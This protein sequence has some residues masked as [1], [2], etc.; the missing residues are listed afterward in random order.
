MTVEV[1]FVTRV[2]AAGVEGGKLR[3]TLAFLPTA[4]GRGHGKDISIA[5]W[6]SGIER[7]LPSGGD[8]GAS[9]LLSIR[10]IAVAGPGQGG[11]PF[12]DRKGGTRL[13]FTRRGTPPG[14]NVVRDL[15]QFVMTGRDGDAATDPSWGHLRDAL[16]HTQAGAATAGSIDVLPVGRSDAALLYTLERANRILEAIRCKGAPATEARAGAP[17]S[18]VPSLETWKDAYSLNVPDTDGSQA[19]KAK[20]DAAAALQAEATR[21]E[22]VI[23]ETTAVIL[24]NGTAQANLRSR[25]L[26]RDDTDTPEK[27]KE[28]LGAARDCRPC[29]SAPLAVATGARQDEVVRALHEAALLPDKRTKGKDVEEEPPPEDAILAERRLFGLEAH[30]TL[31]RLFNLVVD[32]EIGLDQLA[33]LEKAFAYKESGVVDEV[34]E[35]AGDGTA[36]FLFLA[37][38]FDGED[39]SVWTLAKL[40]RRGDAVRHFWPCTREEME[41]RWA[42]TATLTEVFDL[43]AANQVDGVVDLGME[44]TVGAAAHCGAGHHPRY[45][46]VT[47]NPTLATEGA[48]RG[49][50]HDVRQ[51][52]TASR[53]G[54]VGLPHPDGPTPRPQPKLV[55]GGLALVDR[56]R[57]SHIV[58]EIV[59]G[60]ANIPKDTDAIILLDAEDLTIGYKIDVGLQLR[61]EARHSWRTLMNRT[62]HLSDPRPKTEK[63]TPLD[64]DRLIRDLVPDREE[65]ARLESGTAMAASR[66]RDLGGGTYVVH[67][68]ETL[69]SWEGDPL[70]LACEGIS[71]E[72]D[73][74]HDL[75]ISR[76]YGLYA[77]H[78]ASDN[79]RPFPLRIGLAY[80]L[81]ARPVMVGGVCLRLE[82]AEARYEGAFGGRLALPKIP[83]AKRAPKAAATTRAVAARHIDPAPPLAAERTGQRVLRHEPVGSPTILMPAAEA[84]RQTKEAKAAADLAPGSGRV[85]TLRTCAS[86]PSRS[87][88][89]SCRRIVTAPTVSLAFAAIHGR[90]DRLKLKR[91]PGGLKDFDYDAEW[92]EFPLVSKGSGWS[93]AKRTAPRLCT[94]SDDVRSWGRHLTAIRDYLGERRAT[95]TAALKKDLPSIPMRP[96]DLA[97][98]R[99][100]SA[101]DDFQRRLR[102]DEFDAHRWMPAP[103]SPLDEEAIAAFQ[104]DI[105]LFVASGKEP[106]RSDL[107]NLPAILKVPANAE[108]VFRAKAAGLVGERR[109]EHYP[110]PAATSLVIAARPAGS[111]AAYFKG[112]PLEIP[113]YGSGASFPDAIPIV[114]DIKAVR[115]VRGAEP[116]QADIVKAVGSE[117]VGYD[118]RTGRSGFGSGRRVRVVSIELRLGEHVE[119]DVWCVPSA[120]Q[121]LGW[122]DAVESMAVMATALGLQSTG[123]DRERAC[124]AGLEKLAGSSPESIRA[125]FA[126]APAQ[127]PGASW[128]G[129]AGQAP[130]KGGVRCAAD[131]V[132]D[133]LLWRPL[134]DI[135]A[136]STVEAL[137][138]V[139]RP[140]RAPAFMPERA[141]EAINVARVSALRSEREALLKEPD[142]KVPSDKDEGKTGMLFRGSVQVDRDTTASLELRAL[143]V[144]PRSNLIDD[145]NRGRN[146]ED[147]YAGVWPAAHDKGLRKAEALFGFSVAEDGTVTLPQSEVTLLRFDGIPELGRGS[148]FAGLEPFDLASAQLEAFR[149]EADLQAAAAAVAKSADAAKMGA[150]PTACPP[151]AAAPAP[152][153]AS[154]ALL[155]MGPAAASPA[156]AVPAETSLRVSEPDPIGDG[157]ARQLH[158]SLVATTRHQPHFRRLAADADEQVEREYVPTEVSGRERR[159]WLTARAAPDPG[160]SGR[161][162]APM[163]KEYPDLGQP[164]QID[165]RSVWIWATR[166]PDRPAPLSVMPAFRWTPGREGFPGNETMEAKAAGS[167]PATTRKCLLRVRLRRPW[168]SSGEGERLGVVLWPPK[169]LSPDGPKMAGNCMERQD[170]TTSPLMNLTE[171]DDL[172]LG[173][174][175]EFVTRWGADPIRAAPGGDVGMLM[176]PTAFGRETGQS[177]VDSVAMPLPTDDAAKSAA[178][179]RT[180]MEV[181]LL[182]YAPRFDPDAETWYVDLAIEPGMMVEPFVRLGLVRY[183]ENAPPH[184]Q[185]SEPVVEWA[186]ILPTRTLSVRTGK[187]DPP[188]DPA[189]EP[190]V[191]SWWIDPQVTGHAA[192][193]TSAPVAAKGMDDLPQIV[194]VSLLPKMRMTLTEVT[195]PVEG[196]ARS[197][198]PARL[199][200]PAAQAERFFSVTPSDPDRP[201]FGSAWLTRFTVPHDPDARSSP[202]RYVVTVEEVDEYSRGTFP[203]EP[204]G[205]TEPESGA[206]ALSGPRF[207]A[208]M[209]LGPR[210][211]AKVPPTPADKPRGPK[212]TAPA[213]RTHL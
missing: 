186:Q 120:D 71:L 19:Q 118:D 210:E 6:P 189:K 212:A 25:Y 139:D 202:V 15:W 85:V 59:T 72:A 132:H 103:K 29:G 51:A 135:A 137:H 100:G 48:V 67:A 106:P 196:G 119:L 170:G 172:W 69:A 182:T 18:P 171:F 192:S 58:N 191:E 12:P 207:A 194:G 184:L 64:I 148:R 206:P 49:E 11:R 166:R 121:L 209:E 33:P 125:F 122:F 87:H 84:L 79:Y 152:A 52:E 136:V 110:D 134:P 30:P 205:D 115:T 147:Q 89:D 185:V 92:G 199:S 21:V 38:G 175:G 198:G 10:A 129:P 150:K 63:H 159:D 213:S 14:G 91:P 62:V 82:N 81:G 86:D 149:A 177:Y 114:L 32:I 93:S 76:T 22:Q 105:D 180:Y 50:R 41:L 80:R 179:E 178:T 73:P 117:P 5:E 127:N 124:V 36:A 34:D 169:L 104:L 113:F 161:R 27:I 90:F 111:P 95:H 16:G 181:G 144:S 195:I 54:A 130:P 155:S 174:G 42:G 74:L 53:A 203:H 31:A 163:P 176:P 141:P 94:V 107:R 116:T 7:Y 165:S 151:P 8:Q 123:L 157:L 108:P 168:F 200:D 78:D 28:Q 2:I 97:P 143:C 128:C 208:R 193:R 4:A 190:F 47:T 37:A 167:W 145:V 88:P 154:A 187:T 24:K 83:P 156:P 126:A 35:T 188:K 133:F 109:R 70:G 102:S 138:A 68:E 66:E 60:R 45:H 56:W 46:I 183:Q 146:R 112:A 204:L 23:K 57:Q 40:R 1:G 26:S 44:T 211:E 13:T 160:P 39:P 162:D 201:A 9:A 96:I 65:R 142:R 197:E 99:W 77:G 158:L 101:F 98:Y 164:W 131:I 153:A 43:C 3:A 173:P 61:G 140:V 17:A 55:T 75:A 20:C